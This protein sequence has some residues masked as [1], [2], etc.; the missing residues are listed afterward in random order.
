ML[1]PKRVWNRAGGDALALRN[2]FIVSLPSYLHTQLH[3]EIDKEIGQ[4]LTVEHL[5]D[6]STFRSIMKEYE[7]NEK[8]I[9]KY[10]AEHKLRWLDGQLSN[11]A[12]NFWLKLLIRKELEFFEVHKDEL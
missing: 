6:K 2:V 1:Y 7:R 8:R 5:P 12:S 3:R 11:K 10:D 4:D 9:K